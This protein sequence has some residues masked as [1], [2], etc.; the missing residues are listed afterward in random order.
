MIVLGANYPVLTKKDK[1]HQQPFGSWNKRF[2]WSKQS[3][4]I[5]RNTSLLTSYRLMDIQTAS[6]IYVITFIENIHEKYII[7]FDIESIFLWSIYPEWIVNL[8][9]HNLTCL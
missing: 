6:K 5:F 1:M 3:L 7:V 9:S 2:I 8:T 4:T